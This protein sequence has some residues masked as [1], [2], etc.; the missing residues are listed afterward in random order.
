MLRAVQINFNSLIVF[1][2]SNILFICQ[3]KSGRMQVEKIILEKLNEILKILL[4]MHQKIEALQKIIFKN[5]KSK[6]KLSD[7]D[8]NKSADNIT[9][10]E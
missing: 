3:D 7:L 6:G 1:K 8:R 10:I 4:V 9:A 2:Y 5:L